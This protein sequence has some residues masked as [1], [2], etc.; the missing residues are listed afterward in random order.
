MASGNTLLTFFPTDN[1]APTSNYAT[2]DLRNQ[3]PV[4][5]HDASTEESSIFTAILPSQYSGGGLT[6]ISRWMATSATSG[7]IKVGTSIERDAAAG[8]DMDADSFAT[9]QTGTATASGTSGVIFEVTTTHTSGA[10]MDSLA[11]GESFRLKI[12]RKA[13]DGA[14]TMTGDAELVGVLVRE[15]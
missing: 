1:E 9:E 12:A 4:L 10:N 3:H 11:A 2:L 6:I 14:D 13:A 7:D 15:S 8:D 5:D